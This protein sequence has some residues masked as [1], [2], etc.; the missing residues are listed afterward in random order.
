MKY[1]LL[2]YG[3]REQQRAWDSMTEEARNAQYAQAGRWVA[4]HATQVSAAN[5]FQLPHTAT[6]VRIQGNGE[7]LIHDGPFIEGNE[8]VGGYAEINVADLDE[9]LSLVKSWPVKADAVEIWPLESRP[10]KAVEQ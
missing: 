5:K 9:A 8:I 6:T 7:A 1:V 4:E 10:A 3:T 2:F